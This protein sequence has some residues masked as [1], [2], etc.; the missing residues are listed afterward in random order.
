M[1]RLASGEEV[2]APM[3]A[4]ARRACP[5]A[6][7]VREDGGRREELDASG[8]LLRFPARWDI[9]AEVFPVA[10]TV[11][12]VGWRREELETSGVLLRFPAI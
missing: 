7:T 4:E 9:E 11:R 12:E 1:P 5:V 2:K 6:A 3:S 8:V 10:D